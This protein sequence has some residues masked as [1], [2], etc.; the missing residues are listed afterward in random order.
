[1]ASD[2]VVGLASA[3]DGRYRIERELGRGGM[4]TVYLA[5][6]LR[7]DRPVALKVLS[8]DLAA[9]LGSE[10]FQREIR[11]A[12]RLQH[13]HILAVHDSGEA[14][15][16][17]WFTMPYVDG[18]SLRD[19][20]RRERQLTLDEAVRIGRQ[21]ASALD[22]AHRHGV[23]H[24]DIKPENILLTAEGDV[25]VADF[26]V[27][28]ALQGEDEA[29]T[30][31]GLAVGTPMYMSPEQGSG[32]REVDGRSDLYSLGCVVY[33]MLAAEP[34]HTGPSPQ[35]ILARRI[36]EPVRPLRV[37]RDGVPPAVEAAVMRAL[38]RVPADRFATAAE[39]GRALEDRAPLAPVLSQW[40]RRFV[41]AAALVA[42]ALLVGAWW[43]ARD[44][45]PPPPTARATIAI[46]PFT[47]R[48]NP[49][50]DYMGEGIVELLSTKLDRAGDLRAVD[51]RALLSAV[52]ERKS[53]LG[54]D[55]ARAVAERFG[56]ARYVLGSVLQLGDSV[57]LSA[58]L[59]DA[60]GVLQTS[61]ESVTRESDFGRAVD[62]VARLLLG[63]MSTTPADR[64]E[65]IGAVTTASFP[66][67]RAYLDGQRSFRAGQLDSA[68]IAFRRATELDTAFALAWYRLATAAVWTDD[69]DSLWYE[70]MD[71]AVRHAERLSARDRALLEAQHAWRLGRVI[72]AERRYSAITSAHPDDQ[73]AW[74]WLGDIR[75]HTNFLNGRGLADAEPALRRAL[76]LDPGDWQS[77]GHLEWLLRRTDRTAAADSVDTPPDTT[78]P[79]FAFVRRDVPGTADR[80]AAILR[81]ASP[82]QLHFLA[83][84]LL[85]R[86]Y[87]PATGV[88]LARMLTEPSRPP[89]WRAH[90]HLILG[91]EQLAAGRWAAADT[92]FALAEGL[93][94]DDGLPYRALFALSS[95]LPVPESTL[96]GL[97]RRVRAWDPTHMANRHGSKLNPALSLD[98]GR[99]VIRRYLTA[100]LDIKLGNAAAASEQ[101]KAL[102][103]EPDS[104]S[105]G[106]LAN[107][108]AATIDASVAAVK[109]DA[110]AV[111]GALE[112]QRFVVLNYRFI[113]PFYSHG[114]ARLLRASALSR[115][116][117]EDEALGWLDGLMTAER[118]VL[119]RQFLRAPAYRMAGEIHDRRG[120]RQA[121]LEAYGRFVELWRDG[122]SAAQEQVKAVRERMGV[123]AAE[124]RT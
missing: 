40:P 12:A 113:W 1:M 99:G 30:Q 21:A 111:L 5:H 123:L 94:P 60:R 88:T 28:R 75:M 37:V 90:G 51:P 103:S 44:H 48:G 4:A 67:L 79:T 31:T 19:R 9:V 116:G 46:L 16:R 114:A 72:E 83:A 6:D 10:R 57:R 56:A 117:R 17:L 47:V 59:Y 36:T 52:R 107:D 101:A 13:A 27:A 35:A 89:E 14:G 63:R 81:A 55:D 62:D 119:D 2:P 112:A 3:L 109:D 7:H 115:A 74:F 53:E 95:P 93:M 104:D 80:R 70:A 45:A 11:V 50:L 41:A 84:L 76:A 29:L 58:A 108:Y 39:F 77:R 38:A 91:C 120:D 118:S 102:G 65:S 15:G 85:Q 78:S 96:V 33:E 122:D 54:P 68:I 61:A 24:R 42:G 32:D 82:L 106:S 22:Y 110:D 20:L 97:A 64:L 105:L 71:Q 100:L 98:R 25:L 49:T 86:G 18:E 8:P 73:E 23:V 92:Q 66:A 43:L 34:P 121:A 87:D 69:Q 26:G 124:P